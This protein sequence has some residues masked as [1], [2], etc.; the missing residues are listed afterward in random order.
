LFLLL[1]LTLLGMIAM[2]PIWLARLDAGRDAQDKQPLF[3]WSY[4]VGEVTVAADGGTQF[5]EGFG[6]QFTRKHKIIPKDYSPGDRIQHET[7]VIVR[8]YLPGYQ[9][10][11]FETT[12][13][14]AP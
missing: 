14:P 6:Y 5:F 7:G 4:W 2:M 3:C 9:R 10:F 13:P 12:N 8:Y 1:L 11:N